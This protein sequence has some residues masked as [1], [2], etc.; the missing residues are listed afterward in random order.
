M[1]A[2]PLVIYSHK[3]DP[4]GVLSVLRALAPGLQVVGP[5]DNWTQITIT[6]KRFLK[7][8]STITFAQDPSYYTG[9]DWP[10]QMRGMQGYFSR[11]PETGNTALVMLLIQSFRFAITLYPVPEPDLYLGSDDP[12]LEYV[13][14]V[15][16]H[17]DGAIFTP[18]AL[19]DARGRVLLGGDD[20][21]PHAVMPAIFKQVTGVPRAQRPRAEH[22]TQASEEDPAPP[23][24]R[25]VAQR[26][27]ALAALTARALLEQEDAADPGVEQTRQRILSWVGDIDIN[28]EL[29]PDEWKIL[30]RPLGAGPQRDLVNATWRL[31]GLAVLAWALQRFELPPYDRLV[32]PGTLLP[33]VGILNAQGAREMIDRPTLRPAEE[34]KSLQE[35]LFALHWRV[36]DF[37]LKHQPMDFAEFARTAWFGPL[38]VEQFHLIDN[39]LAVGDQPIAR[40]PEEAVRT[41]TSSAMERHLAINWL[42]GDAEIYSQTQAST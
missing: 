40:A 10:T 4:A 28:D 35:Q 38:K 27:C 5:P 39:D 19:R 30:Q 2:E 20:P 42:N 1:A 17:L 13:F 3:V 25:R 11:F 12:R 23:D 32:N 8:A 9:D 6:S 26:A 16:K 24:A 18:S 33:S 14:A 29:E 41:V 31:E 36:T 15:V 7:K 34:L 22:G 37:R 21:D